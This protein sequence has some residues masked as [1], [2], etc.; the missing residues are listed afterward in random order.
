MDA[1]RVVETGTHDELMKKNSAYARL[2]E[3]QLAGSE[4]AAE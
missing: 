3:L 2:V 1:G 4:Q